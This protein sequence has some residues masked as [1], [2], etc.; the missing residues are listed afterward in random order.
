MCRDYDHKDEVVSL[1]MALEWR[2]FYS[3]LSCSLIEF[4]SRNYF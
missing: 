4:D 2:V 3:L 1:E